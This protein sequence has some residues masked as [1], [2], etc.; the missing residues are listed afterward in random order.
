MTC[1]QMPAGVTRTRPTTGFAPMALCVATPHR[2]YG[3]PSRP[4]PTLAGS[5]SPAT[6][7]HTW[8]WGGKHFRL[9]APLARLEARIASA[10]LL[11]RADEIIL[12]PWEPRP[13]SHFLGPAHF[14]SDSRRPG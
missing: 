3:W 11:G 5:T 13:G 4:F 2:D 8:Q 14:R 7:A 6:R 10:D 12:G 1:S 9:G